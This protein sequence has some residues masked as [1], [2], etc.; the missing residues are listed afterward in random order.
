MWQHVMA[1]HDVL[2]RQGICADYDGSMSK[3]DSGDAVDRPG[4]VSTPLESRDNA[5]DAF[6]K[7]KD[8][9]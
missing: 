8:E 1:M 2:V 4:R 3:G 6:W 5:Y 9:A 7:E